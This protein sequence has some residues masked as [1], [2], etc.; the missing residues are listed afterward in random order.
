MDPNQESLIDLLLPAEERV[1]EL[2]DDA[3]ETIAQEHAIARASR[4]TRG[5]EL[6]GIVGPALFRELWGGK[7]LTIVEVVDRLIA[8]A[9]DIFGHV[10]M[11]LVW[12]AFGALFVIPDGL[13]INENGRLTATVLY[14]L[15]GS[16]NE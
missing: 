5:H 8:A 15:P 11:E 7:E 6:A 10:D 4:L 13:M 14:R 12:V 3:L 16:D 2:M 9:G 1:A